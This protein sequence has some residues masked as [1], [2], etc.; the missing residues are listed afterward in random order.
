[1]AKKI[2]VTK[3]SKVANIVTKKLEDRVEKSSCRR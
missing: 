3:M 2:N 1:M